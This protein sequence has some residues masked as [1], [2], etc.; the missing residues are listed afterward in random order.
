MFTVVAFNL[1]NIVIVLALI[2][3]AVGIIKLLFSSNDEEH[4]KKWRSNII[5]VTVGIFVMQISYSVWEALILDNTDRGIN[6]N[7]GW[8]IWLQV[9]SP[10]VNVLQFLASFGF[11][12]MIVY[13]FYLI[14]GGA[15]DEEK[16]KK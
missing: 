12:L 9:F 6:G 15:G 8:S 2:F 11:L 13:A 5:W 1:K 16:T 3:L 7:L 4:V 10:I 14:V